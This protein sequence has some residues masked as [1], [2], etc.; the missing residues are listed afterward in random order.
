MAEQDRYGGNSQNLS[1][2]IEEDDAIDLRTLFWNVIQGIL[3]FWWLILL[4]AAVGAGAFYLRATR[5]FYTPM[6]Q[7]SATFTVLTGGTMDTENSTYN[8]YYDTNTVGQLAKTFPYILSSSLLTEAIE[9][10]LGVDAVNGRISAQA[11][12][13]SNMITMTVTSNSPEDARAI[14]E[15]TIKVYPDVVRFVIGDTRFS[16]IDEPT[17][18]TEPYNRPSY[19]DQILKGA[20][21]G[22][23]SGFLLICL[24]AL[25]K[26]TVQKPEELNSVMS[27]SCIANIPEVSKK[28]R[29]KQ[30]TRWI[31]MQDSRTPQAFRENIQSLQIRISRELEEKGGKV[32]V[33]TSTLPGEGKSTLAYNLAIAAASHGVKVLFVDADLRKKADRKHL[34]EEKGRGLASVVTGKCSL[35]EAVY[36]EEETGVDFLG[37]SKPVKGVQ[38][39][40][41]HSSFHEVIKEMKA[42][43]DLILLD[44]PPTEM[45]EDASI[46]AEQADGILYVIRYDQVQKRRILD[47]ISG[48]ED[49]SAPLLGYVFNG[50]PV[51]RGGYGYYGYGRYGYGYYG[52]GSYGYGERKNRERISAEE[53]RGRNRRAK[54]D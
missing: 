1:R 54:D 5:L 24:C 22:A 3:K 52:Y 34:T 53:D 7:S 6:Y 18:P 28:L 4:L 2:K 17:T 12:S 11:V 26:K 16:M 47:S 43:W 20:L 48:L 30:D 14:L 37:G 44:A 31:Q 40:L 50:V 23:G 35:Q 42:Q 36:R 29:K 27:L 9:E 49:S 8:F 15:S 10:D 33:L 21:F 45:F 39:I 51:H 32:L 25:F 13:D 19:L 46:L 38:Q 41:N